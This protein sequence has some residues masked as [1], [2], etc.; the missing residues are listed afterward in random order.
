MKYVRSSLEE[1]IFRKVPEYY[2]GMYYDGFTTAEIM[3]AQKLKMYRQLEEREEAKRQAQHDAKLR[4]QV[5][6]EM[7]KQ[8]DKEVDIQVKK[9]LEKAMKD[10][11]K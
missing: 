1:A 10:L 3:Y 7:Q 5:E 6:K 11:F 8:F 9:A 2:D 4:A